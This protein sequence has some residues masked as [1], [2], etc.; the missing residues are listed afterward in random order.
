MV[1]VTARAASALEELLSENAAPAEAGVRLTPGAAGDVGMM[2]EVPHDGD[3]VISRDDAPLLIV[4]RAVAP[5]LADMV[6]DYHDGADNHQ[7]TGGFV[8]RPESSSE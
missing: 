8:L 7:S 6:V 1:R 4:D 5:D 3:E 2:I